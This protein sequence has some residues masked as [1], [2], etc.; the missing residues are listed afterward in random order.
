M[1]EILS[2]LQPFT[3][4]PMGDGQVARRNSRCYGGLNLHGLLSLGPCTWHTSHEDLTI[5]FLPTLVAESHI[6]S[7]S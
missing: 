6:P 4:P 3:Q 5:L 1:I 2:L 7:K